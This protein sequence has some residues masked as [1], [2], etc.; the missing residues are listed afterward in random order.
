MRSGCNIVLP[1]DKE[2]ANTRNF[3]FGWQCK[4]RKENEDNITS[5]V[6]EAMRS[7]VTEMS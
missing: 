5:N 4:T 7:E 3:V 6:V 1:G 2:V